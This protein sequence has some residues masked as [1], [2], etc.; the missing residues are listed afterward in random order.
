MRPPWVWENTSRKRSCYHWNLLAFLGGMG[1]AVLSGHPDVVDP[2]GPGG[3]DRLPGIH[4]H[5]PAIS[6]IRRRPGAQGRPRTGR[7]RGRRAV[8]ERLPPAQL[9][10]FQALRDRCLAL[11]Q[12]AEQL[13]EPDGADSTALAR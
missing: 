6:E 8:E 9:R 4:R 10:R 11:R 12:I 1:F 13:R 5:A 7:R 3:R 2:A